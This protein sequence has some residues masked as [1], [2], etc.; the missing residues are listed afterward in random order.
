MRIDRVADDA[1]AINFQTGR[2]SRRTLVWKR[3]RD[4][5]KIVHLHGSALNSQVH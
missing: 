3:S 4:G 1:A 5:W 2:G